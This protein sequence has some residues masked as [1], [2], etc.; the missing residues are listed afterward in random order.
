MNRTTLAALTLTLALP[1]APR[2]ARAADGAPR[3][4]VLVII[5]DD[6]GWGDLSLHGN[7]NLHTPH[8]D[9]L[10][11]SGASLDRFFVQPMCA[12]T[13]AEFLTGRYHPRGGVRGVSSGAE[14]LD[15]DERTIADAFRSAGYATACFGKWHNGSQG[16]YHPNSRGFDEFYGF[17]SGHWGEYFSPPLEH[18]G[19]SVRGDGFLADDLTTRAI[20]FL[21]GGDRRA[22]APAAAP[23]FCVVAYNTPHSPMQVPDS[24]W[25]RFAAAELPLRATQPRRENMPHTRAALAMCENLDANVG[26]LLADID[27]RAAADRTVVV[28]FSDNGPNGHRW[29]G[30]MRSV[31]GSTDEGGVRSPLFI[32]WPGRIRPAVVEPIAAAIDLAPTLAALAGV[33]LPAT[34]LDGANLAP[35]LL[36]ESTAPPDRVLVQHWAGKTSARDGRHRLD[37][38]GRLYDLAADPGQRHDLAADEPAIARTLH[39]A[40]ERWRRDVLAELPPQDARPFPVGHAVHPATTLPARDGRPHGNIVRSAPPAN[41]AF[42]TGWSAASDAMT[43]DV[44]VLTPGRYEAILAY[45][46]PAG[47]VGARIELI[48]GAARWSATVDRAHDP[49]L[50]GRE[51]DRVPRG[52]SYVKDFAPLGLGTAEL[53]AGRGVLTLRATHIPGQTVADVDSITLR[54]LP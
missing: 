12:P 47:S 5:A 49:P 14:R 38:Q 31:K 22:D 32:R 40:V 54:R 52:E 15:L 2:S 7:T 25:N 51:H 1:A 50:R 6:M 29:N 18:N 26:R 30:R 17:T 28:F 44:E 53:A 39:A 43:W 42:F 8:L 24:Y 34:P 21:A 10:A 48:L 37:E 20:E 19:A 23:R 27:R 4:D 9:A 13:R 46:C 36:G 11:R 35:L 16:P 45:T 41:A 33:P 3:P